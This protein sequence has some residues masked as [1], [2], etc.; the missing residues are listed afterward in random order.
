[1]KG[2]VKVWDMNTGQ[3]VFALSFTWAVRSVRFSP[4][5]RWLATASNDLLQVWD[6]LTGR[7]ELSCRDEHRNLQEVAFSPDGRHV[8]AVGGHISVHFDR[9]VKVWDSQTGEEVSSLPGHVGGLTG[10]AFSP[11]GRRLASGGL[12]QTVK[13][14][15]AKTGDE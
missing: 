6:A 13:L 3:D 9:E 15:D 14:W 11:D 10:V 2:E 8:A 4:D 12:D 5:G 7:L 1:E